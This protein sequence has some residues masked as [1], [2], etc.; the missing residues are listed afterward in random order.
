MLRNAVIAA[1]TLCIAA[2]GAALLAQHAQG[3][4]SAA[5]TAKPAL[6]SERL[7]THYSGLPAPSTDETRPAGMA[8]IPG[9]TF[10]MGSNDRY[11]EEQPPRY[12][13]VTG[14]WID[15][16]EVTNAQFAA[17]V[18]A[19]GYKTVA[20]RGLSAK[21]YPD[22]PPDALV[23]GAMVFQE[24]PPNQPVHVD[25]MEW[26]HYVPGA[27]W[28]HPKGPGSSIDGMENHPVVQVAYADAAAY[29]K[30]AGRE[31][32][33][34]AEWEY[35]AR[36]GL[37]GKEFAWGDE[38]SPDGQ[39][40]ANTWQGFFPYTDDKEDGYHGTAPVGCFPPNGYGL[41]DMI[42][43][44]WEWASDWYAPGHNFADGDVDPTGPKNPTKTAGGLLHVIK[45]GSWLCAPN[46]CARYRPAARQ[47]E[48]TDLGAS[49]IGF[50]TISHAPGPAPDKPADTPKK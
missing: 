30:W 13:T 43:N 19:T 45:G 41:F 7:C 39:A 25:V 33:T 27:N 42:G 24:P 11:R 12:A 40:M 50:R 16:T 5:G 38:Q 10:L 36:G 22:L 6:S 4:A 2:F 17:F 26:W 32:P 44:V 28:R 49:H 46:F 34:E 21:D 48:E 1:S 18:A 20:E 37:N 9:G 8:W 14:F 29:A 47:P 23:P 15:R 3:Q 35:A 31:L